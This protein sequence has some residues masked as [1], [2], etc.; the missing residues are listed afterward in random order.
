MTEK[1]KEKAIELLKKN[2]GGNYEFA[3]KEGCLWAIINAM[4]EFAEWY[5][6][7]HQDPADDYYD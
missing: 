3:I 6:D 2:L 5:E 4:G 7:E 1:D